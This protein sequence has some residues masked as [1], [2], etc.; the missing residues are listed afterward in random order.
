MA[1]Q[2]PL[3]QGQFALVDD[4]DYKML[5]KHKWRALKIGNTYYAARSKVVVFMHRQI[6]GLS[7]GDDKITDHRNRNGLDNRRLN[8]RIV[9]QLENCHNHGAHPHN[10]SGH[11]GVYWNKA[12]KNWHARIVANNK[13]IHL[14]RY[15][16][17]KDAIK[18]RRQGELAYW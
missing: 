10:T 18:A 14:G 12:E 6:L 13:Q 11:N 16:D 9:G 5:N 7:Q 17:I 3:T 8:L 1:K 15:S 2:I 4:E